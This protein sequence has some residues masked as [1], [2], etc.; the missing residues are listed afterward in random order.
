M[1]AVSSSVARLLVSLLHDTAR[2][3]TEPLD[4]TITG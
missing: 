4:S 1:T 3:T 2:G